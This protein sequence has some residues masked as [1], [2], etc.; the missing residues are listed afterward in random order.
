MKKY[1]FFD[2]DNT[3]Y[4]GYSVTD[5]YLFLADKGHK[6]KWAYSQDE[7]IGR[8]YR[9]GKI[10]YEEAS[11]RVAK[12]LARCVSGLTIR[13]VDE[14]KKEFMETKERLNPWV[15]DIFNVLEGKGFTI[16]LISA[17]PNPNIEAIADYLKC[18]KYSTSELELKNGKYTGKILN[19]LNYEEKL[20]KIHRILGHLT[21]NSFKI[22][23]GDS[24]GDVDMLSLMDEAFLY[25]PHQK[26]LIQVAKNRGW[27]VVNE[28]NI[29]ETVKQVLR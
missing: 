24:S 17:S 4:K 26:K 7:E 12:V 21:K 6:S 16:Y 5:F 22:G 25:Q 11:I 14:Y 3:L 10:N 27:R 9:S 29:L 28:N 1:A 23:F 19:M 20:H 15:K 13:Q 8:Y 18:D 2:V